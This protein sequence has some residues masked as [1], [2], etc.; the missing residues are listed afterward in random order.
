MLLTM[1]NIVK[2]QLL[3][4]AGVLQQLELI[5]TPYLSQALAQ[6]ARTSKDAARRLL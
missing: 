2:H 4:V 1:K 6:R 5:H 3:S